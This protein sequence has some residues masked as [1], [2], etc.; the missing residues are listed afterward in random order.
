MERKKISKKTALIGALVI[1]VIW[2]AMWGFGL[3]YFSNQV[4]KAS[5]LGFIEQAQTYI[6]ESNDFADQYG[7]L[8]EMRVDSEKPIKNEV[9][10]TVQYYMD[11]TCVTANGEVKVRVSQTWENDTWVLGYEELTKG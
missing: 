1:M 3:K 10:D 11:F 4:N 8:N 5:T 6:T 2:F 9:G 7:K